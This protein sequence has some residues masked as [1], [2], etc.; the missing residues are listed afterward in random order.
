MFKAIGGLGNISAILNNLQHIGPAVERV[1]QQM[2]SEQIIGSAAGGAVEVTLNGIGEMQELR[3]AQ[4]VREH[5]QLST[6]IIEATNDAGASAKRRYADAISQ[7]ADE[8]D[9]KLPAL[10]AMLTALTGGASP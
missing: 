5:E 3:I 9:L 4:S 1:T 8:L 6:W 10:D 2:R 7:A